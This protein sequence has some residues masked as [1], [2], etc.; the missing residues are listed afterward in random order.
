MTEPKIPQ[1]TNVT[2]APCIE[3]SINEKFG[4][5]LKVIKSGKLEVAFCEAIREGL[6]SKHLWCRLAIVYRGELQKYSRLF[7]LVQERGV[8]RLIT[9]GIKQLGKARQEQMQLG[10]LGMRDDAQLKFQAMLPALPDV[11]SLHVSATSQGDE[12]AELR[13]SGLE[14]YHTTLDEVKE[15]LGYLAHLKELVLEG[16]AL[17][18]FPLQ[19]A[20]NIAGITDQALVDVELEIVQAFDYSNRQQIS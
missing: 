4:N 9:E 15:K 11:S 1:P 18:R 17:G 5:I 8:S 20:D 3:S 7:P 19:S 12:K 14:K 6:A 13:M 16:E 10:L 2:L